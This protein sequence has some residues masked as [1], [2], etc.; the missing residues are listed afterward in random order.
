MVLSASGSLPNCGGPQRRL[1]FPYLAWPPTER[2]VYVLRS[3][4]LLIPTP[5]DRVCL[6][7]LFGTAQKAL[8][9]SVKLGRFCG[10]VSRSRQRSEENRWSLTGTSSISTTLEV[11]GRLVPRLKPSLLRNSSSWGGQRI[12]GYTAQ[13]TSS[14]ATITSFL[15]RPQ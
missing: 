14:K 2:A 13:A 3:R 9:Q 6:S 15:H 12:A 1:S 7:H 4:D 11:P 5:V 8:L 10:L